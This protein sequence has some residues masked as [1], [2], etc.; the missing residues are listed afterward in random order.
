MYCRSCANWAPF[1]SDSQL[2][3]RVPSPL[4]FPSSHRVPVWP[5]QSMLPGRNASYSP[6]STPN[7]QA[8][9]SYPRKSVQPRLNEHSA[10]SPSH[11]GRSPHGPWENMK[12]QPYMRRNT[13][14]AA[15]VVSAGSPES[16]IDATGSVIARQNVHGRSDGFSR[17]L[18]PLDN[19]VADGTQ[20]SGPPGTMVPFSGDGYG[21]NF[22]FPSHDRQDGVF[23]PEPSTHGS[24]TQ[25]LMSP[26]LVM[27]SRIGQGTRLV[28]SDFGHNQANQELHPPS[29]DFDSGPSEHYLPSN[30][31]ISAPGHVDMTLYARSLHS[32]PNPGQANISLESAYS[33]A[34][35]APLQNPLHHLTVSTQTYEQGGHSQALEGG[36]NNSFSSTHASQFGLEGST[37]YPIA[38]SS[39]LEPISVPQPARNLAICDP[40]YQQHGQTKGKAKEPN[41]SPLGGQK[42][43]QPKSPKTEGTSESEA[44]V[45]DDCD[46]RGSRPPGKLP[47]RRF[48]D[49]SRRQTAETRKTGA[50]IRCRIQRS[51]VRTPFT[52]VPYMRGSCLT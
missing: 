26:H 1:L 30:T 38:S 46:E 23:G 20:L 14:K 35:A 37:Q 18:W 48:S 8:S 42:R 43:K 52:R 24:N 16:S 31:A 27:D 6:T 47:R 19:R 32:Q 40:T 28:R 44:L 7:S 22:N 51:R 10:S 17:N 45:L 25:S 9:G 21:S 15:P 4:S 13:E 3:T 50:C 39:S 49:G 41:D 29:N 33:H 2:Q 34:P 12:E 5:S 36:Y 11:G